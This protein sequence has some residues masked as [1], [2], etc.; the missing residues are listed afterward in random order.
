MITNASIVFDCW[1]GN[2]IFHE[3]DSAEVSS[4]NIEGMLERDGHYLYDG[5]WYCDYD[6]YIERCNVEMDERDRH[7]GRLP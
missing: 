5:E 4:G 2:T 1:C 7:L 6:C 3:L